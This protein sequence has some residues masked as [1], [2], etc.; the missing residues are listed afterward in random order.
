MHQIVLKVRPE[1]AASDE[2]KAE[3]QKKRAAFS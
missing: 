2:K 1:E 3:A